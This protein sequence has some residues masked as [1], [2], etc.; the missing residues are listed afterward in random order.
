[1]TVHIER[2]TV[3]RRTITIVGPADMVAQAVEELTEPFNR[4]WYVQDAGNPESVELAPL[5]DE[6][7]E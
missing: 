2:S 5:A 1:M 7:N 3:L 6:Q 4:S